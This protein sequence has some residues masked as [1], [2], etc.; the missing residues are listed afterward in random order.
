MSRVKNF[1]SGAVDIFSKMLFPKGITCISCDGEL[2]GTEKHELCYSCPIEYNKDFCIRCGRGIKNMAVFCD[3]CIEHGTYNFDK[4]RS[5]VEYN[6][7]AK[8]LIHNFKYANSRYLAEHL[9]EFM[10][11][12][13]LDEEISV[14]IITCVPLHPKR[15][16]LRGYNQAE[17]LARNLSGRLSLPFI[18]LLNKTIHTVNLAKLNRQERI[19]IVK[20]SFEIN[21]LSNVNEDFLPKVKTKK[22]LKDKSILLV[23]DVLTT[24]ATADECAKM[25]KKAGAK[26]VIVLTYTSVEIK[27]SQ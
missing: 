12:C 22:P 20:D 3:R 27:P 8:R 10:Y 7:T 14:D 13:V 16:R 6:E 5:S 15:K 2:D 18:P 17:L 21:D 19:A 26:E 24:T 23:D 4:A 25:L 9:G 11:E 1:F